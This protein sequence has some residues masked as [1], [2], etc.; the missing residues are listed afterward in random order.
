MRG[1]DDSPPSEP[2]RAVDGAAFILDQPAD[3]ESLWGD[4]AQV[5][6]STGEALMIAGSQGLGKTTLA[7]LLV[8]AQLGL[9][10]EVLGLPV[11]S[12][13]RILYLAMDRPR[14]ISRSL[15]RQ[16][17]EADRDVLADRLVILPGPPP[18]D[19]A[20]QPTLL[21]G[22]ADRYGAGVVVVD[23]LKDAALRLSTDEVGAS[24]NRG[25]Q[26]LLMAGC[27]L[28]EL[29][30][31][32]KR[33]PDGAAPKGINDIYGSAWLTNGCGSVVLLSGDPGDPIVGFHH[34]KQPAGEVG[35]WQLLHDPDAGQL[36][37]ESQ[38]DL[39]S[40]VRTK[41]VDGLTAR[42]AAAALFDTPRPSKAEKEK[43]RRRLA[44]LEA[45]KDLVCVE[46]DGI[47]AWFLA[48]RRGTGGYEE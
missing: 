35:P 11:R 16:F 28:L 37:V 10:A 47:S 23:S 6:W 31:T 45:K 27:E 26:H 44:K 8:R 39:I 29:H 4:G 38:V 15:R 33:G 25:R 30:H 7:G 24:Y 18:A 46:H 9:D 12:V 34:V 42:D 22:L 2:D 41:G 5:L 14:Q 17:T 13:D 32:V 1:D 19:L 36:T 21:T 20:A 3:V 40:L 48:A 43:A